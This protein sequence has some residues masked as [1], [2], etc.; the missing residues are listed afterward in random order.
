MGGWEGKGE[1]MRVD[2]RRGEQHRRVRRAANRPSR[3]HCIQRTY[4][5]QAA[6]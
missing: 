2:G 5:V 4:D 6:A 3:R 1:G